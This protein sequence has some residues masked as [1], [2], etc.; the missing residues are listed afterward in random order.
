MMELA[1]LILKKALKKTL[2]DFKYTTHELRLLTKH[3]PLIVTMGDIMGE[4]QGVE[5]N[6]TIVSRCDHRNQGG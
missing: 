5:L 2:A 4:R 3:P 1:E 6:K